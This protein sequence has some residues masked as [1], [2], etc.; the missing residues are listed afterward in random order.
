MQKNDL[1]GPENGGKKS[2]ERNPVIFR[3]LS[4]FHDPFELS[5]LS[6]IRTPLLVNN[7]SLKYGVTPTLFSVNFRSGGT[8]RYSILKT[9]TVFSRKNRDAMLRMTISQFAQPM[10]F[11]ADFGDRSIGLYRQNFALNNLQT[12]RLFQ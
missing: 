3:Q 12:R 5:G 10:K 7:H 6:E 4:G 2:P 11:F 8:S 9:D 1:S